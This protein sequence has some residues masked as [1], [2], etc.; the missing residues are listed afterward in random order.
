MLQCGGLVPSEYIISAN[1]YVFV[2]IIFCLCKSKI[3]ILDF[4]GRWKTKGVCFDYRAVR[5]PLTRNKLLQQ[6][7]NVPEVYGDAALLF[8]Y[9]YKPNKL[10]LPVADLCLV[11]H[12]GDLADNFPWWSDLN[13]TSLIPRFTYFDHH[14]T[15]TTSNDNNQTIIRVIDIRT[16][17]AA[18]FIDTMM[19][20]KLVASASLH[21]MIL[22]EAYNLTWSW[23]RL[24]D[25]SEDPFKY[26]DFFESVGISKGDV[27]VSSSACH[28]KMTYIGI[29]C[30]TSFLTVAFLLYFVLFDY[31]LISLYSFNQ[32]IQ[33]TKS[34]S[35]Q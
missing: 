11:P 17:N 12:F 8:P 24:R 31:S 6:G 5:G 1:E 4:N 28:S 19:T 22:A 18:A 7:C 25:K 10:S 33:S 34:L 32:K 15:T 21:G 20:C 2:F 35:I 14:H 16:P 9:I 3:C 30:Q 23:I 13:G 27:R 29:S 26:N